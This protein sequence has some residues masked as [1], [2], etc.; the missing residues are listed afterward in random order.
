MEWGE[1]DTS[2]EKTGPSGSPRRGR[3]RR[4]EV[5]V[6]YCWIWGNWVVKTGGIEAE[7]GMGTK[8][9]E[10]GYLRFWKSGGELRRER[11]K[12]WR[13]EGLGLEY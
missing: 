5:G 7:L 12:S 10:M 1:P 9:V 8:S 2:T 6:L 11:L 3:A 4:K 13:P